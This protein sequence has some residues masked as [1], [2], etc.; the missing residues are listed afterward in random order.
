MFVE[1]KNYQ[2]KKKIVLIYP[3][4]GVYDSS[5]K[6]LPLSLLSVVRNLDLSKY[7]VV[8][9]DQRN[10]GWFKKLR[11]NVKSDVL[12]FGITSLTGH[13]LFFAKEI[14]KYIRKKSNAKIVWGGIHSTYRPN[15]ILSEHLADFVLLNEGD[16]SFKKLVDCLEKP[17]YN[18]VKSIEG[19]CFYDGDNL[20]I[21]EQKSFLDLNE[22][23]DLPYELIDFKEYDDYF[24]NNEI[25]IEASRGCVFSC[26]FCYNSSF[27]KCKWRAKYAQKIVDDIFYM[28]EKFG[29][30]NFFLI[31]D[32]FFLDKTRVFEFVRLIKKDGFKISWSTEG[33]LVSL[34]N[35]TIDEL[36]LL[37]ESGL[38]WISIGI[39]SGSE[40]IRSFL[41]KK[42]NENDLI[43]FNKLISKTKIIPRYNFMSGFPIETKKDI[44]KTALLIK[45]LVKDNPKAMIQA[46]YFGVPYPGTKYLKDCKKYGLVEPKNIYE[47]SEYDSLVIGKYLPWF[48][49]NR[50]YLDV[51]FYS[52]YFID[53]K[54]EYHL[55]NS[56]FEKLIKLFV[57]VYK[58]IAIFRFYNLFH[59]FYIE[60]YFMIFYNRFFLFYNK[61]KMKLLRLVG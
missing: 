21:N 32:S 31:D 59:F 33:N 22:L 26:S 45:K 5:Y 58:P 3:I 35:Y 4:C 16:I 41:N 2:G 38:R 52:S 43:K 19:I 46:P 25:C 29:Y 18:S 34:K 28:I 54:L 6:S 49:K 12:L 55:G 14:V 20:V 44:L 37:G 10:K 8:I 23:K 30:S 40:K 39:E 11:S 17:D 13:Q 7:N 24:R 61:L 51:L 60:K 53:N 47:W 36:N 50:K 15:D 1:L 27:N 42:I 56:F 9:I 48:K 57:K